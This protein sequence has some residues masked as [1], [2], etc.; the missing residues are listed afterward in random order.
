MKALE[1]E[2]PWSCKDSSFVCK[3]SAVRRGAEKKRLVAHELQQN[4]LVQLTFQGN[5]PL[6]EVERQTA[7]EFFV[8]ES[9]GHFAWGMAVRVTIFCPTECAM[10]LRVFE[11]PSLTFQHLGIFLEDLLRSAGM[12]NF[13]LL[14]GQLLLPLLG[15]VELSQDFERCLL[16][17]GA[18][19]VE[20]LE[21][22][23]IQRRHQ[24]NLREESSEIGA[25]LRKGSCQIAL[26]CFIVHLPEI[27]NTPFP[28]HE[29][30]LHENL[31]LWADMVLYQLAHSGDIKSQVNWT[32]GVGEHNHDI[33]ACRFRQNGADFR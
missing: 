8:L 10:P 15:V 26:H 21:M 6:Y 4:R 9:L 28:K 22:L 11:H 14:L 25:S 32:R 12:L 17:A 33:L 30:I 23:R 31:A 24:R 7:P 27:L 3:L 29:R 13:Q 5:L 16:N 19:P 18:K 1:L 2:R 20:V